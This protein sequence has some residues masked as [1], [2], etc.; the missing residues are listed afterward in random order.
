MQ[1]KKT[2][3]FDC[4]AMK[5]EAQKIIRDQVRGMTREQE[6]AYFSA[7]REEFERQVEESS[8][9]LQ[10]PRERRDYSALAQ[11]A[12]QGLVDPEAYKE[13]RAADMI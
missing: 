7:G 10:R 12:G 5:R 9:P 4:I 6:A 2:K 3:T 1:S 8:A 13:L 11:I